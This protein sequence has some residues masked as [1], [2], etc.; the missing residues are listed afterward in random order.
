[1]MDTWDVYVYVCM[2]V[3]LLLETW[4][5]SRELI[6]GKKMFKGLGFWRIC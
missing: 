6:L 2:N 4:A 5:R 1:M 3:F